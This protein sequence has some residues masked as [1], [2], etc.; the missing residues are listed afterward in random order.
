[1]CNTTM[2]EPSGR[3]FR[4]F[5][6]SPTDVGEERKAAAKVIADVNESP[7]SKRLGLSCQAFLWERDAIPGITGAIQ[8]EINRQVEDYDV[9]VGILAKRFGTPSSKAG[10]GTE[11]EFERA[12]QDF[13]RKGA[14]WIMFYLREVDLSLS[15]FENAEFFQ[16]LEGVL[17]FR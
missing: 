11:E 3:Q 10:S 17:R 15:Y 2:K 8:D 5:I 9:Y 14:P 12:L 16:Q 1:M 7:L 4:V 13:Q 6:S